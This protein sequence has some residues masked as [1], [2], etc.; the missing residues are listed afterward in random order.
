MTGLGHEL[1]QKE[2]EKSA[3]ERQE[4]IR[5]AE[6]AV[7]QEAER[8]KEAALERARQ[9]AAIEQERAIKKLKKQHSKDLLVCTI[10]LVY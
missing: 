9:E 1:H 7:W 5:V 6:Q 8:L 3:T 2:L 4:A 10:V